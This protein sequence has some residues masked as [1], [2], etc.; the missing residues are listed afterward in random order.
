MEPVNVKALNIGLFSIFYNQRTS[1]SNCG[2]TK[3]KPKYELSIGMG[4]FLN[5]RK[6]QIH[7]GGGAQ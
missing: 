7:S 3:N 5:G 4:S 2:T 6:P 1:K